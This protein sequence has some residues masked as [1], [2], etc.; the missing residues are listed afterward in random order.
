MIGVH[1]VTVSDW[2]TN[3]NVPNS[4]VIPAII[5]FLEYNPFPQT[6]SS[7]KGKE[8]GVARQLLGLSPAEA[9]Q[10]LGI[11]KS[12]LYFWEHDRKTPRKQRASVVQAFIDSAYRV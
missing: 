2:E 12:T 6:D 7:S 10:R 11:C 4:R 3:E 8:I 9:A 1:T 5:K